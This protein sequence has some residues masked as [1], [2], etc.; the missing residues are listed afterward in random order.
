MGLP[1]NARVKSEVSNRLELDKFNDALVLQF[2]PSVLISLCFGF[3]VSAILLA[4]GV[5]LSSLILSIIALVIGISLF[6]TIIGIMNNVK[7]T[8]YTKLTNKEFMKLTFR[9]MCVAF[10]LFMDE[11][12]IVVKGHKAEKSHD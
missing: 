10:S 9:L 3:T 4:S 2:T 11:C 12:M 5:A 8:S 7:T 6:V 1:P